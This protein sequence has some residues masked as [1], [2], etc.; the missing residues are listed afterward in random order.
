M[1]RA[2]F[3]E[4]SLPISGLPVGVS[5]H[6]VGRLA[7]GEVTLLRDRR[8]RSRV[9]EVILT[10]SNGESSSEE[11][12]DPGFVLGKIERRWS[13]VQS[14]WGEQAWRRSIEL[15]RAGVIELRCRVHDPLSLGEPVRWCLTDRWA[16]KAKGLQ[17]ARSAAS[18]DW[19]GRGERAA[20]LVEDLCPQLTQAIRNGR[21]GGPASSFAI[22]VY[23]AEDLAEG[24]VHRSPRAFAQAHL[25]HTKAADV[26]SILRG[27]GVEEE[28]L[29]QLGLRR[30]S[31]IGVAGIYALV[32][33]A[34]VD[35][36]RLDGPTLLRA[37][38]A[39]LT[40]RLRGRDAPLA[41]VENLQAAESIVDELSD[42]AVFY[43]AGLMGARAL[44]HLSTLATEA[45]VVLVCCDAD[46]GGVRITEQV[47]SVAPNATVLDVGEWEHPKRPPFAP[48]GVSERGLEAALKGPAAAFA[49]ACLTRGYPVE[50]ELGAVE[51][52]RKALAD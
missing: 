13:T 23:A 50:Q 20:S 40:L 42:F 27:I 5:A 6:A 9:S 21:T 48:G 14:R 30:S 26:V 32:D 38:Q 44:R 45:R 37:D 19:R 2:S 24:A 29:V 11:V 7:E 47:L 51:L 12:P 25:G 17:E 33:N 49:R 3:R 39:G 52:L 43:T 41:V 10:T 16:A 35:L 36:D 22:W 15:V 8:G 4:T 1:R 31:R 28:T 46:L 34:A 18:L